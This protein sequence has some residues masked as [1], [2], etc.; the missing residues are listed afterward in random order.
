MKILLKI[1]LVILFLVVLFTAY[2]YR[3][4]FLKSSIKTYNKQIDIANTITSAR[5]KT[6][7]K[8]LKT[9]TLKHGYNTSTCF[10]V[11]MSVHCGK[12]RFFVYNL[13]ADTI[14][15][16]G[17]VAHG[18]GNKN[19][20]LHPAFSNAANSGYTSLGKYK[21]SYQY[22]GKFGKAYKLNGLDTS[23][24]NA[25]ERNVV[26]HAYSCVPANE[27]YPLPIC[28]SLGCTMVSYPFLETLHPLIKA[29]KKPIIMWV[30]Q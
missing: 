21:V 3:S 8:A 27:T 14:Q 28:N 5:L 30:Y 10:L 1:I 9:Y 25:F 4:L 13:Q 24:S 22:T 6:Y 26:L 23:N 17:L 16:S 2:K 11:D 15:L 12:N 19:F 7:S 20:L 18:S 29:S